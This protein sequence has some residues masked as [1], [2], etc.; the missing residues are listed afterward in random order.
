MVILITL[1]LTFVMTTGL[2]AAVLWLAFRRVAS[3]LKDNAEAVK[4]VS[5]HVFVPLFGKRGAP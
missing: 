4:Q 3:H 2:Y 1:L 5:E